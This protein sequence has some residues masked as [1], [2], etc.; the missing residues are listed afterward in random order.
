MQHSCER[1]RFISHIYPEKADSACGPEL[2][3]SGTEEQGEQ[4]QEVT[5]QWRQALSYHEGEMP[6]GAV[7]GLFSQLRGLTV[8]L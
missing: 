4:P 8:H 7:I 3:G 1:R 5:G 2:H 6:A